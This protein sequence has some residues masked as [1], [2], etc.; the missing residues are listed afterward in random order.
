MRTRGRALGKPGEGPGTVWESCGGGRKGVST[1]WRPGEEPKGSWGRVGGG[2][3]G[4]LM[5]LEGQMVLG[6][7]L[8]G[9]PGQGSGPR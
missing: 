4:W 1:L 3:A 6:R 8:E 2:L 9:R 5:R 7:A